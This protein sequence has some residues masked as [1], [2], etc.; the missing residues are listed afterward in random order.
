M[1]ELLDDV[2]TRQPGEV[3]PVPALPF[4]VR[5]ARLPFSQPDGARQIVGLRGDDVSDGAF[6][7]PMDG[8]HE[9]RL[10]AIERAGDDRQTF[11]PGDGSRLDDRRITRHVD[12][13]RF[14]R[15]DVLARLDRVAQMER[16]EARRRSEDDDVDAAVDDVFVVVK[17]G[18]RPL[19]AYLHRLADVLR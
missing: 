4:H 15:E 18:E 12:V 6:V 13:G 19:V 16:P 3:V 5:H 8:L 17:A 2:I 14:L 7:N 9:A 11:L 1:D 10:A